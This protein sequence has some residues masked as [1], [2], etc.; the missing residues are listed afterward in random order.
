[1][2]ELCSVI[3][4]G[5]WGT[6]IATALARNDHSVKIY[7]RREK[8]VKT[9]NSA[10][11]N[12]DY[13]PGVKL[14]KQ[15]TATTDINYCLQNAS[16]IFISVPTSAT[17]DT[18]QQISTDLPENG[19][20]ISTAKGLQV[21]SFKTNYQMISENTD[22]P[23]CVL[24]GP[25]HAEEVIKNQPSAA[26][27]ASKSRAAARNVQDLLRS[28]RFRIYTNPDV[29]GVELGGAVKN[30]IAVAAGASDG[31]GYGDNAR[32]ALITRGLAEIG[33]LGEELGANFLSFSG[34]S[35]LGDLI[36][37][38]NSTHSRNRTFGYKIGQG[39][40][41]DTAL[42]EVGQV[43]E[44]V[45]TTRAIYKQKQMGKISADMP[46][47]EEIYRVLFE[48][49]SPLEAVDNLM[50]RDPKTELKKWKQ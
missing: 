31:L 42:E 18:I 13:F 32:A 38:C 43:V 25:T 50:T 28:R 40:D 14:P 9:I 16:F 36:V 24:S 12:R 35:G 41:R 11:E 48:D 2:G 19:V 27:V 15:V 3:G 49:K 7:S 22:L 26:V 4:C 5:S 23:V 1:M 21:E 46:I 45:R 17:L 10:G 30:V 29:R 39:K 47:T 33:R 6:A 8:Q 34:L 20:V 44:G 37:T